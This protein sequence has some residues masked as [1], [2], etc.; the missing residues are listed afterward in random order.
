ME[1]LCPVCSSQERLNLKN[2]TYQ[3]KSYNISKCKNCSFVYVLNPRSTTVDSDEEIENILEQRLEPKQRHFQIKRLL[4]NYFEKQKKI[5]VVEVGSGYGA[6]AKIFSQ[7]SR[8]FY[9]GFEPSEVRAKSCQK[10]GLNVS[11]GFF[12]LETVKYPLD[13]IIFDNVLEHVYEPKDLIW[14][15]SKILNEKGLIIVI[16]PNLYDIRQLRKAWRDRHLWQPH[17]HINYFTA[18]HLKNLLDECEFEF[19]PFGLPSL[20]NKKESAVCS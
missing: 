3:S 10:Q 5:E 4:D 18:N 13:A 6:L 7:D 8:Y 9:N 14:S 2:V 1:R 17:C 16:V 19:H 15:A 20:S 11:Q 12:S